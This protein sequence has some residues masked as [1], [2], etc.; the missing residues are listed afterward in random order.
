MQDKERIKGGKWYVLAVIAMCILMFSMIPIRENSNAFHTLEEWNNYL[1]NIHV[2]PPQDTIHL[3]PTANQCKGC[4]GFDPKMNAM[5]DWQGNDVNIHDDWSTSMMANSAKDP[6]WRAKVSHEV[7]VNPDHKLDLET[8]CTSCHAPQGHFTSI[9]RGGL[10]YT[11]ED[12]KGDT[13][14]LDGVSC[15]ACHMKS[16]ENLENLFSGE[17]NYDTSFVMFGPYQMPFAAPMRDFVGFEPIYSEHI[18]SSGI[19]ASCHTLMT[20]SVDLEGEFTGEMFAEQATY[21]EWLNSDFDDDGSTPQSCQSCHMPRLEDD[22]VISANYLFLD[23]RSPYGL[24]DMIGANVPMIKM[25]KEHKE[26]LTIDAADQH[27]DETIAKTLNML[28]QQSLDVDLSLQAIDNDTLAIELFLMNKAGHKFPSGY[29]SRRLF[30]EFI[31]KSEAGDTIF[32]SGLVDDNYHIIGHN[33]SFEP[34][35]EVIR[36][37]DQAQIYEFVVGDVNGEVT[38]VLER[39]FQGLKDNRLPPKGFK[40]DHSSYDTTRIVGRAL[41]DVNFNFNDEG[42]GSGTDKIEYRVALNGFSG[43]VDVSAK[44]YYQALPPRWLAPMFEWQS[45]EIDSFEE[46]YKNA[47]L[48]PVLVA[49]DTIMDLFVEGL[50]IAE[51]EPNAVLIY[52]NPSMDGL[53]TIQSDQEPLSIL[54]YD[55]NG[56]KLKEVRSDFDRLNLSPRNGLF[57]MEVNFKGSKVYKKIICQ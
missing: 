47:D 13:I 28:Q 36:N 12:L 57:I 5:I 38:T 53:F 2:M 44:V 14:G 46:M 8:K 54:V 50:S 52:P 25:M 41:N 43:W 1:E 34:H 4:H 16:E 35:Y 31:V 7:L 49:Q 19:C 40:T 3:F 23:P 29:P 32:S 51:A 45:A 27:F 48:E 56:R 26:S 33:E 20:K 15:G 10:H 18:N 22:I 17:S 39:G 42:E 9:L 30:V 21:H 37:S 55:V 24:H 11:M 6:F